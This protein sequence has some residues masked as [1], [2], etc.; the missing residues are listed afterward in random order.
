[1]RRAGALGVHVTACR[2]NPCKSDWQAQGL[3]SIS[4]PQ[5]RLT[6]PIRYG[7]LTHTIQLNLTAEFSLRY[8]Q[9]QD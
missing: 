5:H 2:G 4:P 1:M 8:R 7:I 6:L 3:I 9:L